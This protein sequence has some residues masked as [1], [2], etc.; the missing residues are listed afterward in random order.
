M[1][2][3]VLAETVLERDRCR[4]MPVAVLAEEGVAG[5][6][7][8][9]SVRIRGDAEPSCRSGPYSGDDTGEAGI[10]VGECKNDACICDSPPLPPE[11]SAESG[12]RGS[13]G[14]SLLRARSRTQPSHSTSLST[15]S[16]AFSSSP[17]LPHDAVSVGVGD[18]ELKDEN[19]EFDLD[20][21]FA[22][23]SLGKLS[24]ASFGSMSFGR[25]AS[26]GE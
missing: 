15:S 23:A 18:Q 4:R 14:R 9:D 19:V 25:V 6:G 21:D 17:Q 3:T 1:L 10:G 11:E 22:I 20:R 12:T 16:S 26:T 8:Y 5:C 24:C 2:V 7:E 13:G